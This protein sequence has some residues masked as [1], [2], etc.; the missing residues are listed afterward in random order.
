MKARRARPPGH[1]LIKRVVLADRDFGPWGV[2]TSIDNTRPELWDRA[3]GDALFEMIKGASPQERM[4]Q[5]DA[6]LAGIKETPE[7]ADAAA[8][9]ARAREVFSAGLGDWPALQRFDVAMADCWRSLTLA[10]WRLN[11][12]EART[13]KGAGG[14][15]KARNQSAKLE[16]RD[17]EIRAEEVRIAAFTPAHKIIAELAKI[18][19]PKY[20]LKPRQIRRIVYPK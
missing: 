5:A 18:C 12:R 20:G 13:R 14:R 9:L 4:K 17:D 8:H 19:G 10:R 15:T 1:P 6:A 3:A 2:R 7:H 11:Q 16:A